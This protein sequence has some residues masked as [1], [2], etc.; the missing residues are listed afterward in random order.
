AR[1][2]V[3][4]HV[5]LRDEG[6]RADDRRPEGGLE[7][8]RRLEDVAAGAGA[9]REALGRRRRPVG[10]ER[11]VAEPGVDRRRR[12]ETVRHERR[13]ADRLR[14]DVVRPEVQMTRKGQHADRPDA[15]REERVDVV[16]AEAGVLERAARALRVDLEGGLVGGE[17]RRV[18]VGADDGDLPPDAHRS[19]VTNWVSSRLNSS[20]RSS[21]AWWPAWGSTSRRAFGISRASSSAHETGVTWSSAPATTSVGVVTRPR[22]GRPS[23]AWQASMSV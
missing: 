19:S 16:D 2:P 13:A 6:I 23:N 1:R 14:V 20:A 22:S 8:V 11:D 3:F 7:V 9:D 12:V 5:A 21:G 17:A 4:V 15:A 10:D 18:L